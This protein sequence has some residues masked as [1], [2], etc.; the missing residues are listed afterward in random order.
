MPDLA[1]IIREAAAKHG[2]SPETLLRIA[3]IESNMDPN[4]A[5]K[6]SSAR[7]VFQFI[8]KTW[9]AYGKGQDV[10]DPV[11]NA[12]AGARFVRDNANTLRTQLGREPAP[13]EL[14]LA[15]QQGAGGAGK[16]LVNP[17]AMAADVTSPDAIRLNAGNTSMSAGDFANIWKAKFEGTAV[18]GPGKD[19][20][21]SAATAGAPAAAGFQPQRR[22]D[23]LLGSLFDNAAA[24]MLQKPQ[25]PLV[26]RRKKSVGD[27]IGDLG[28][29]VRLSS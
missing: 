11:A 25:E 19:L 10:L 21:A 29:P 18:P 7:G 9:K 1:S 17:N 23:L 15:H 8:D 3:Q 14:Y 4:A 27:Q 26:Q 5:N 6:D 28:Q 20:V 12:D 24:P 16:L 22:E 2:V 13:W